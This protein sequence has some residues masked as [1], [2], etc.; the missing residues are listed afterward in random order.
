MAEKLDAAE[1]ELR[2]ERTLRA[3]AEKRLK[4]LSCSTLLLCRFFRFWGGGAEKQDG[5]NEMQACDQI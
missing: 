4:V 3:E 2:E 1:E 5:R